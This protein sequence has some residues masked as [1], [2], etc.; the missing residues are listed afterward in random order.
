[1]KKYFFDDNLASNVSVSV[2]TSSDRKTLISDVADIENWLQNDIWKFFTG[3]LKFLG[4]IIT[5][6]NLQPYFFNVFEADK[7]YSASV[8]VSA[9]TLL[10]SAAYNDFAG[11]PAPTTQIKTGY[12]CYSPSMDSCKYTGESFIAKLI[13]WINHL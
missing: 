9:P 7:L 5:G 11:V 2:D 10:P 13:D 1:V 4:N 6:G 3:V 8:T 12:F